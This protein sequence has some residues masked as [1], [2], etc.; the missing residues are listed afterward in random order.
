MKELLIIEDKLKRIEKVVDSYYNLLYAG[1]T[2]EEYRMMFYNMTEIL[3]KIL[4][5]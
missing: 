4:E 2:D 5:S 3:K 1:Y